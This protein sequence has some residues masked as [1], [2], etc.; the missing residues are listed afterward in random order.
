MTTV[1]L[2]EEINL[3]DNLPI[4]EVIR[5]MAVLGLIIVHKDVGL[6]AVPAEPAEPAVKNL[7]RG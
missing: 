5:A 3:P 6:V 4:M 2:P 1:T 7:R